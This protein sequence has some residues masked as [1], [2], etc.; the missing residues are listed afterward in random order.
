MSRLLV[1]ILAI[2]MLIFVS[3][4][5]SGATVSAA[6][7]KH[8]NIRTEDYSVKAVQDPGAVYEGYIESA[9]TMD[10]LQ[11]GGI[12]LGMKADQA[13]QTMAVK[14]SKVIK[15]QN[16]EIEKWLYEG[17]ELDVQENQ[18]IYASTASKE[19]AT[20]R[21]LKVGD[22]AERLLK[23]YGTPSRIYNNIYS[24]EID[25]EHYVFH[26]E[27]KDGKVIRIQVNL[28]DL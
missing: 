14:P 21:G 11:L 7:E 4:C 9:L 18:V 22:S 28:A 5:Q 27:V 8:G 19:Y 23:L 12:K 6:I 13:E 3:G 25:K 2:Y 20:P 1:A 15:E 17:I 24:F 10:D 26:A 16:D